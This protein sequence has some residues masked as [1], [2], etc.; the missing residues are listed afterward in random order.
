MIKITKAIAAG[1]LAGFAIFLV[2]FIIIRVLIVL[3]I[4]RLIFRL[5]GGRRHWHSGH[6]RRG[7]YFAFERRWEHMTEDEKKA[8]REKM[9]NDYFSKMNQQ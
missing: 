4:I 5:M 7:F 6:R 3:L 1:I 9:E 8:F 2:P